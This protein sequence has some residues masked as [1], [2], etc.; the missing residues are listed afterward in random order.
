M[1]DPNTLIEANVAIRQLIE[2][3]RLVPENGELKIALYGE[4]ATLQRLRTEPKNAPPAN[5]KG[6]QITMVA[7]AG[8]V[9]DPTISAWV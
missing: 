9:Q 3:V 5:A 8:F 4:L 6:V 7:G 2:W 1:N